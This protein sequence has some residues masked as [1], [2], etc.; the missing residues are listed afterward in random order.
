MRVIQ[1]QCIEFGPHNMGPC[2]VSGLRG[3]ESGLNTVTLIDN[4]RG[5]NERSGR[6]LFA[7]HYRI[8]L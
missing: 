8:K 3:K 7:N 5:S 6:L 4:T 1:H 2:F